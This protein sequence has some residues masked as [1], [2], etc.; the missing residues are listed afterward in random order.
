[1][2]I[3]TRLAPLTLALCM[4]LSVFGTAASTAQA[5]AAASEAP[6]SALEAFKASHQTVVGLVHEKASADKLK[7]EVDGLLDYDWIAHAALGGERR[8]AKKCE[9]RCAEYEA[10]L[11][12]L[13]REN[14]LKRIR[15]ADTGTVEYLGEEVR[16]DKAKVDTRVTFDKDGETQVLEVSY[17]MH[18]V[19]GRWVARNI[20]TDGVS[21]SKTYR[22]EFGKI[23]RDEGID[24]LITRLQTKLADVAKAD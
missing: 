20:I 6:P 10:L 12:Q 13:I 3:R 19:D 4:S 8:Y 7:A 5:A 1:M 23:V 9:P 16:K 18:Y 24:G 11:A 15:Q 14:Y 21:L 22:Y 17:V 2:M